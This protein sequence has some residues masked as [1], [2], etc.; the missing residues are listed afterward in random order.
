MSIFEECYRKRPLVMECLMHARR[1]NRLTHAF[2]LQSDQAEMRDLFALAI[3]QLIA[4]SSPLDNGAPCGGCAGCRQLETGT[5]SELYR[6]M[7]VGKMRQIPVGAVK[8]PEPNTVRFFEEQFYMT[9]LSGN[10]A[11]IGIIEDADR[12]GDEA[13][14]ALLKTLEEPPAGSFFILITANPA[15]LLPTTRS[16]CQLLM[17]LENSC[18]FAFAGAEKVFAALYKLAFETE[19]KAARAAAC[20]NQLMEV[21]GSLSSSSVAALEGEYQER[22]LA[23]KEVDPALA[24]RLEKQFESAVAGKYTTERMAF[25]ESIRTFY[26]QL[27]ALSCGVAMEHL[28]N[29]ELF[30][31]LPALPANMPEERMGKLEQEAEKLLYNFRYNVVEELAIQN[32]C[33]QCG[34]Y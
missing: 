20:A 17:L 14:N 29:P 3:A 30:A 10:R 1:S 26:G 11:K 5:Y 28:P 7:P 2:L 31:S 19:G 32:F 33:L 21:M 9:S 34:V 24:K 25:L 22:I 23:A 18:E 27:Y 12:L 15:A 6:L 13:Q 8:N 16:R 4:C